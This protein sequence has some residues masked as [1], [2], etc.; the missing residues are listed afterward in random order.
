MTNREVLIEVDTLTD[1]QR[2][3]RELEEIKAE[4]AMLIEQD[5]LESFGDEDE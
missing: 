5:E 4:F 2:K 1:E 3:A